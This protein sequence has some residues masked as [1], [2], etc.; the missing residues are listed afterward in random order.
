MSCGSRHLT[1]LRGDSDWMCMHGNSLHHTP[2]PCRQT[3]SHTSG[4]MSNG[5][6]VSNLF[7]SQCPKHAGIF[8]AICPHGTEYDTLEEGP[9][10]DCHQM[11]HRFSFSLSRTTILYKDSKSFCPE[12]WRDCVAL[13]SCGHFPAEMFSKMRLCFFSRRLGQIPVHCI[14]MLKSL[15]YRL[16]FDWADSYSF[17]IQALR[18]ECIASSLGIRQRFIALHYLHRHASNHDRTVLVYKTCGESRTHAAHR[19]DLLKDSTA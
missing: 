15:D 18:L 7:P 4:T 17:R 14:V 16:F 3:R 13:S 5:D 8:P 10:H 1:L 6:G 11:A 9:L 2:L 12:T 19:R